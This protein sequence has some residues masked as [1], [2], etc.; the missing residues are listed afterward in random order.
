MQC[1]KWQ[2]KT[3]SGGND[4]CQLQKTAQSNFIRRVINGKESITLQSPDF[5]TQDT[6]RNR[7]FCIYNVSLSCPAGVNLAAKAVTSPITDDTNCNDYLAIYTDNRGENIHRRKLCG[8]EITQDY[9]TQLPSD[10][11]SMVLWTDKVDNV[12]ARFEFE[13]TCS[14]A[15][16]TEPVPMDTGSGNSID[17]NLLI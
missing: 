10:S 5:V 3:C 6:V 17:L 8:D 14:A 12:E 11:F 4:L 9:T 2:T 7:Y 15:I 1:Y 13:A 16:A